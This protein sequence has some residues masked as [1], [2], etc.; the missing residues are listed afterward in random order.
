M[1][2]ILN[3]VD[4]ADFPILPAP[5]PPVFLISWAATGFNRLKEHEL[6]TR[7]CDI[8]LNLEDNNFTEW[9]ETVAAHARTT[10]MNVLVQ[11]R[12]RIAANR[13]PVHDL[14]PAQKSFVEH[15]SA[16]TL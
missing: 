7:G 15:Y 13:H 14:F 6:V 9:N 4:D 3:I 10:P 16:I 8:K 1:Q 2:L 11:H 12:H 5:T